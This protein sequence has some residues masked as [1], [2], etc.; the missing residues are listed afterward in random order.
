MQTLGYAVFP[1]SIGHCGIAWSA[2][3][4][5]GVQL[6]EQDQAATRARMAMRFPLCAESDPPPTVRQAINA[7]VALLQGT[8]REPMDLSDIVLDL[9]GI[10]PFHLRVYAL[11]RRMAPGQTTTYGEMATSI[12]LISAICGAT[13]STASS[14]SLS[15][16]AAGCIKRE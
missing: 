9:D 16:S 2:A 14:R 13:N 4:L 5:T 3:G 15:F 7:V 11:T 8:P 1:T 10:P 6:P 12:L